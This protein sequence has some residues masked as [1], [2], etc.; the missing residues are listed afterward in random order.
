VTD[1]RQFLLLGIE[2]VNSD[3]P[4]RQQRQSMYDGL[5]PK[6]FPLGDEL[7]D[8][9]SVVIGALSTALLLM[10]AIVVRLH[11]L[12]HPRCRDCGAAMIAEHYCSSCD[13]WG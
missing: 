5:T 11:V 10:F 7:I 6:F 2:Q 12:L 4:A 8:G 13:P 9:V 1:A 3:I